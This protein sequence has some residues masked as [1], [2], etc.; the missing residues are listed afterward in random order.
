MS[1][2]GFPCFKRFCCK[3]GGPVLHIVGDRSYDRKHCLCCM[4]NVQGTTC[5]LEKCMK[6]VYEHRPSATN[7]EEGV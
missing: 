2:M 3:M 5:F 1:L 7:G 4:L 6:A